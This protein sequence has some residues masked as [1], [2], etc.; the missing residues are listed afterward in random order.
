MS[1]SRKRP[2]SKTTEEALQGKSEGGSEQHVAGTIDL[3]NISEDDMVTLIHQTQ[4]QCK[5]GSTALDCRPSAVRESAGV[6]IYKKAVDIWEIIRPI[7]LRSNAAAGAVIHIIAN[8]WYEL[9]GKRVHKGRMQLGEA[10]LS[11]VEGFKSYMEGA[12]VSSDEHGQ[13]AING[14]LIATVPTEDSDMRSKFAI[15]TGFSN[16]ATTNAALARA[17]P[18]DTMSTPGGVFTHQKIVEHDPNYWAVLEHGYQYI[19]KRCSPRN[20]GSQKNPKVPIIVHE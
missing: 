7:H 19:L 4:Q 1:A 10:V 6:H 2:R 20:Q 8:K 9:I 15:A 18:R 3:D 12:L 13:A 5:D 11:Q 17:N 14:A 16:T